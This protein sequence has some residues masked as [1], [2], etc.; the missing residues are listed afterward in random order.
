MLLKITNH[1]N[2][3]LIMSDQIFQPY[4]EEQDQKAASFFTTEHLDD[5]V[6]DMIYNPL[7]L[8]NEAFDDIETLRK[9]KEALEKHNDLSNENFGFI[10]S[11]INSMENKYKGLISVE[12]LVSESFPGNK[13]ATIVAE[14]ISTR[15]GLLI[16]G[17][18]AAII[19]MFAWILGKGKKESNKISIETKAIVADTKAVLDKTKSNTEKSTSKPTEMQ[20][21]L[22]KIREQ[23][24]KNADEAVAKIKE[25]ADLK[26]KHRLEAKREEEEAKAKE[27]QKQIDALNEARAKKASDEREARNATAPYFVPF[28]SSS[29]ILLQFVFNREKTEI[30]SF[31]LESCL[32]QFYNYYVELGTLI[33]AIMTPTARYSDMLLDILKICEKN[34]GVPADSDLNHSG[35]YIRD[36]EKLF[37]NDNDFDHKLGKFVSKGL[38]AEIKIFLKRGD[39]LDNYINPDYE[40]IDCKALR[41]EASY[42][43]TIPHSVMFSL[44][45]N[46]SK[47]PKKK[48]FTLLN[49]ITRDDCYKLNKTCEGFINKTDAIFNVT[50]VPSKDFESNAKHIETICKKIDSVIKTYSSTKKLMNFEGAD[51]EYMVSLLTGMLKN[52]RSNVALASKLKV[53]SEKQL[54]ECCSLVN[55]TALSVVKNA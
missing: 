41:G 21:K 34:P 7:N 29:S 1:F 37:V 38:E 39:K 11:H 18:I 9:Y 24:I 32:Q 25:E 6:A 52:I 36:V 17:I 53:T 3:N 22:K 27:A 48:K 12:T 20:E 47:K 28:T 33:G 31:D 15:T 40:T 19:A 55:S 2:R 49:G 14:A 35:W 54:K 44:V 43:G 46:G 10:A 26:E 51:A 5:Y 30:D 50:S 42:T 45:G 13:K 16:A 4:F 8:I 23:A